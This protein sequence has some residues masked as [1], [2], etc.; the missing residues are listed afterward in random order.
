MLGPTAA[1]RTLSLVLR[2]RT[3]EDDF[4]KARNAATAAKFPNQLQQD[5][6][7]CVLGFRAWHR[8]SLSS[9]GPC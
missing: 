9:I 5:V 2:F 1:A 6:V 4:E 7:L 8:Y 3:C